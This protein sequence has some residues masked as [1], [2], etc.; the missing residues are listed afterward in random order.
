MLFICSIIRASVGGV[1]A[2]RRSIP[3]TSSLRDA[4]KLPLSHNT[5]KAAPFFGYVEA[6]ASLSLTGV[7]DIAEMATL[8]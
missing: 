1:E 7:G 6:N 5:P 4:T 2:E 3:Q 8:A